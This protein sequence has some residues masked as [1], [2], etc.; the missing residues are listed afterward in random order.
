MML[1]MLLIMLMLR[2]AQYDDM[3]DAFADVFAG[4]VTTKQLVLLLL[5]M[6]LPL[7]LFDC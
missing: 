4:A 5:L 2:H 6:L 7:M 1:M 3:T